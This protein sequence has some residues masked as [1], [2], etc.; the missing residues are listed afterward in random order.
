MKHDHDQPVSPEVEPDYYP[1]GSKVSFLCLEDQ[2]LFQ[3]FQDLF[4]QAG[5]L[6]TGSSNVQVAVQRLRL[7][8]Y[9]VVVIEDQARFR[10]VFQETG[11][12]SGRDRRDV[13]LIALGDRS[14]SLH[15]QMA[16]VLGVNYYLNKKDMPRM[17]DLIKQVIAGYDEYYQPW[18]LARE[19]TNG[20]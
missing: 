5:Y 1:P 3:S 2:V 16:F 6:V 18:K 17:Q 20:N 9:Q 15:Q 10:P 8:R 4:E 11:R 12:W 14:A 7:N 13:N 19:A